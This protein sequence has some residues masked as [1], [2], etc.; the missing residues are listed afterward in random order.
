MGNTLWRAFLKTLI[1][2]SDAVE[3]LSDPGAA[4]K[5]LVERADYLHYLIHYE[6]TEAE[7]KI[8]MFHFGDAVPLKAVLDPTILMDVWYLDQGVSIMYF[9][10][11]NKRIVV[12]NTRTGHGFV[13]GD[14]EFG[15]KG[16][17][18]LHSLI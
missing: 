13:F 17:K 1:A 8:Q 14:I 3:L 10:R 6:G 9:F 11:K 4:S 18:D 5:E 15:P 12:A 7:Q 2:A 16:S